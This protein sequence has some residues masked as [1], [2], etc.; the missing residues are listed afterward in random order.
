MPRKTP[1]RE[2][3]VITLLVSAIVILMSVIVMASPGREPSAQPAP[4]YWRA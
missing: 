2:S 4:V 1:L 3:D